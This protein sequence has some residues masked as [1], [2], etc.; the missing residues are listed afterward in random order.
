VDYFLA[1][2][3]KI[4]PRHDIRHM[5]TSSSA[6]TGFHVEHILAHNN[7]NLQLFDGDEEKFESERN[8]LGGILLLKGRDNISSGNEEYSEKLKTYANT[9]YWNETLREDTYKSK[10]DFAN[11]MTA[12]NL[13]FK[14]LNKFGPDELEYRQGLLFE[15]C[16]HIWQHEAKSNV[17][18]E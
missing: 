17:E 5:V 13:D 10:L 3:M 16:R 18:I 4:E 12:T 2:G 14:H 6:K 15:I 1:A 7:T 11:F 9:L 8:R